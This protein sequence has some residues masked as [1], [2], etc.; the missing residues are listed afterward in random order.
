MSKTR[1]ATQPKPFRTGF[2][3]VSKNHRIYYEEFGVEGGLPATML[4]GGPG[5]GL[6]RTFATLFDLHKWHLVLFDQRGCGKSIPSSVDRLAHNTT[7]DLVADMEQLRTHLGFQKWFVGGG[8]WGTTLALAYAETHPSRVSGILL[9]GVCVLE[10]YE[11]E[12]L[13]EQ[14]GASEV[15]P[16]T[17]S[18]FLEPLPPSVRTKG[19]KEIMKTYQQLLTNPKTQKA[20]VKGWWNWESSVSF[21]I[22]KPDDTPP[23]QATSLALLENHYFRH[24]GWLQPQQLI[25][26]AYR[27]KGIPMTIV[28][29]RYDMVCPVRSAWRLHIAVPDSKLVIVPNAGHGMKEPKTFETMKR[30]LRRMYRSIA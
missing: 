25:K 22:P 20:A 29:G 8:S 28:H 30:A 13:Y 6:D 1:K 3:S 26:N 2:L 24:N 17:W 11:F 15:F 16:D 7:W 9:R 18:K 5:G 21:L 14:G 4:H 19:Y 12:W 23:N 27:L 10:P